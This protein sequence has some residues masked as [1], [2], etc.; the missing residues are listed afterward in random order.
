MPMPLPS[1]VC[2]TSGV[3][4]TASC[5]YSELSTLPVSR[6]AFSRRVLAEHDLVAVR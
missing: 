4:L 1:A 2:V 6:K 5:V 3:N